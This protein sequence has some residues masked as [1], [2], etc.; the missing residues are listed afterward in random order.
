M[1]SFLWCVAVGWQ[2]CE[3]ERQR[4][5]RF[6]QSYI[7]IVKDASVHYEDAAVHFQRHV[8]A[9]W[10]DYVYF[11]QMESAERTSERTTCGKDTSSCIS[12]PGLF[13]GWTY[14]RH[15]LFLPARD[16]Q[17]VVG[18]CHRVIRELDNAAYGCVPHSE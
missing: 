16:F 5:V 11:S 15:I 18:N 14:F 10:Y 1:R 8:E 9:S 6:V 4:L 3:E 12:V 7:G 17:R 13:D 2:C